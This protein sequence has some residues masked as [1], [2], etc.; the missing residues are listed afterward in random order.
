MTYYDRL[1]PACQ[2]RW[3]AKQDER[4]CPQCH[5][6]AFFTWNAGDIGTAMQ[7]DAAGM[8]LADFETV[9]VGNGGVNQPVNDDDAI[10]SLAASQCQK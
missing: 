2:I 4:D 5:A 3:L 8:S 10:I 6:S 7:L 9:D 1:C